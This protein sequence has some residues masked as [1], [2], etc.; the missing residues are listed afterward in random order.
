MPASV[1]CVLF[2]LVC[3]GGGVGSRSVFCLLVTEEGRLP[4]SLASLNFL[5]TE[6]ERE[7][8]RE[9]YWKS[10]NKGFRGGD[11]SEKVSVTH[12]KEVGKMSVMRLTF[13]CSLS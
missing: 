1:G 13:C 7:R 8:E 6:R 11:S 12:E 5:L 10:G 2:F 3:R 4:T 9:V